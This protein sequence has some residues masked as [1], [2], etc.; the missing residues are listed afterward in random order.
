MALLLD[1]HTFFWWLTAAR[2]IPNPASAAIS[3]PGNPVFV[4]AVTGWEA[5]TKHRIG[6]WDA[7]GPY[8]DLLT[9]VIMTNGFTI[10][11]VTMAHALHAGSMPGAHRDP[12]DRLLAAQA[13]LDDLI[14]VS[15]D[16]HFD[17]FEVRRLW[18]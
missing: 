4:S 13:H 11:D 18:D 14:L 10:L 17:G 7:V 16:T 6:K 2:P 12:F 9:F 3:D 1:T 15:A 8:L 5:A